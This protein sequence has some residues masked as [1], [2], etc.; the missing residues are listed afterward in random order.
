MVSYSSME[1]DR[2]LYLARQ[3]ARN[4]CSRRT[5]WTWSRQDRVPGRAAGS[6]LPCPQ[7]GAPQRGV[8]RWRAAR[9]RAWG[10]Q[11]GWC[12]A[13]TTRRQ[14]QMR[15]PRQAETRGIW[16]QREGTQV[17]GTNGVLL[18]LVGKVQLKQFIYES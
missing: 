14:Q 16:T 18:Y 17:F 11:R 15:G 7:C 1:K 12:A 3:R 9:G 8:R 13:P 2:L 10:W 5:S 4:R 6:G